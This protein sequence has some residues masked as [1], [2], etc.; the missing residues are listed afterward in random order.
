MADVRAFQ[1]VR[2]TEIFELF[3]DKQKLDLTSAVK[4]GIAHGCMEKNKPKGK[5]IGE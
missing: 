1:I 2:N 5:K 3:Q 4:P